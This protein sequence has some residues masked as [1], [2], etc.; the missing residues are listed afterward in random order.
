[1]YDTYLLTID[2]VRQAAASR[3]SIISGGRSRL[4]TL[5]TSPSHRSTLSD[6]SHFLSRR[7]T[8]VEQSE[9]APSLT[10]S[11][12]SWKHFFLTLQWHIKTTEQ[13]TIIHQYSDWDNGRCWV[14]CNIWYS[15]GPGR[16][17][18]SPAHSPPRC[19]KCNS[20]PINQLHII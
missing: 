13:R 16:A 17:H 2:S 10:P 9:H 18:S 3:S 20:P 1:M 4:Y 8:G 14:D 15:E 12:D 5:I 11:D 19:T 7:L 6:I